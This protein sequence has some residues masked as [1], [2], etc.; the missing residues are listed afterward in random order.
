MSFKIDRRR[1]PPLA[2][3]TAFE[4]AARLGSFTEAARELSL[5]QS[6]I[7]RQ[8]KLLEGHVG[9]RLFDRVRQRV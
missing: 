5:T 7:S 1:L 8:V 9:Q 2:A 3:L 6:A 4:S